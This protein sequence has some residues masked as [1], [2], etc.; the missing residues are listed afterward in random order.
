MHVMYLYDV[1]TMQVLKAYTRWPKKDA[2][3]KLLKNRIKSY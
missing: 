1:I 3:T 2:T